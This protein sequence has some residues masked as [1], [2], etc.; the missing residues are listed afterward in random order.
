MCSA[1]TMMVLVTVART[2]QRKFPHQKHLNTMIDHA[3]TTDTAAATGHTLSITDVG[4]GTTLTCL[5]HTISLNI[6]EIQ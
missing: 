4:R 2:A 5:D 3:P 6:T 1:T